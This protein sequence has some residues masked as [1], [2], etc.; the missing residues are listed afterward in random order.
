MK[1]NKYVSVKISLTEY[2]LIDVKDIDYNIAVKLL[3]SYYIPS[4]GIN[5]NIEN[6]NLVRINGYDNIY[7]F[8]LPTVFY[9]NRKIKH[10]KINCLDIDN[11][12]KFL[13]QWLNTD[14]NFLQ[15]YKKEIYD[16]RDNFKRY[17][18]EAIIK[19]IIE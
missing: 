12:N 3:K 9:F 7:Q 1:N 19:D 13:N 6:L 14:N 11:F 10:D 18:E 15:Y 5:L 2:Y 8:I 16:L 17:K 4:V